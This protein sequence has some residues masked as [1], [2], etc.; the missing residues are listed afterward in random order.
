MLGFCEPCLVLKGSKKF[1]HLYHPKSRFTDIFAFIA[2]LFKKFY[3][4]LFFKFS[5]PKSQKNI[6]CLARLQNRLWLMS[7]N[8]AGM[9]SRPKIKTAPIRLRL[10]PRSRDSSIFDAVGAREFFEFLGDFSK[11]LSKTIKYYFTQFQT[12]HLLFFLLMIKTLA[13]GRILSP[14]PTLQIFSLEI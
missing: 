11:I 4:K 2:F 9:Q 12:N 10:L 1:L 3:S 5:T 6:C 14:S 8:Q 13:N 7:G